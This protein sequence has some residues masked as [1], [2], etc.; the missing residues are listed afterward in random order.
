MRRIGWNVAPAEHLQSLFD[1]DSFD[2]GLNPAPRLG[3]VRE[4]HHSRAIRS[5]GWQIEAKPI[6]FR[7]QE[8][9]GYLNQD[10]GAIA[11]VDLGSARAAVLQVGQ[12]L[13]RL[14]DDGVRAPTFDVDDETDATGVVLERGIVEASSFWRA[15]R[16]HR[17]LIGQAEP[18]GKLN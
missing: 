3:V 18:E 13:Q 6:R 17:P 16:L 14:V 10:T 1:N 12:E 11:G 7:S 2:Q 5:C 8:R 9:V 15:D 4:E